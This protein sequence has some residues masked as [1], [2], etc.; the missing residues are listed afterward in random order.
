MVLYSRASQ[1]KPQALHQPQDSSVLPN[2]AKSQETHD[3]YPGFVEVYH[4]SKSAKN[5]HHD[6]NAQ[7][8]T[9]APNTAQPTAIPN[10]S[11]TPK[12]SRRYS[13]YITST[14]MELRHPLGAQFHDFRSVYQT[15]RT[16][17]QKQED[18][19]QAR[20]LRA[21]IQREELRC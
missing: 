8:T 4:N 11:P 13:F 20:L 3:Y 5:N 12:I 21:K 17:K 2:R 16:E 7:S 15:P 18:D 19:L 14:P 1:R 10:S 6:R 9:A